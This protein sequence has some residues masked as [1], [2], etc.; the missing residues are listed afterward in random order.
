[1]FTHIVFLKVHPWY[2]YASNMADALK[3]CD[4]FHDDVIG[5]VEGKELIVKHPNKKMTLE[6]EQTL[7]VTYDDTVLSQEKTEDSEV[8]VIE[9]VDQELNRI[10][11]SKEIEDDLSKELESRIDE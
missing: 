10:E 1:M 6:Q 9:D 4:K 2:L 7:A 5:V 3:L 8:A 11:L